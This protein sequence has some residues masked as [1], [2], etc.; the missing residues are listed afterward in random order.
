MIK[1]IKKG[2]S[3]K[4]IY[5]GTCRECECVFECGDRDI[6]RHWKCLRRGNVG[7]SKCPNC[8]FMDVNMIPVLK[9]IKKP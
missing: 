3:V 5:R 6:H 8:G 1:I 4:L 9:N 2:R 7:V